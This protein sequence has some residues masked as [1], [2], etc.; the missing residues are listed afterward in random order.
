[1]KIVVVFRH[2]LRLLDKH[3]DRLVNRLILLKTY[4]N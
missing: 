1:M 2:R 4:L 3:E